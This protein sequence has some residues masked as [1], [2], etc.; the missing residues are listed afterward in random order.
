MI[1]KI[2]KDTLLVANLLASK[3][4]AMC[5]MLCYR[6]QIEGSILQ[7]SNRSLLVVAMDI[8]DLLYYYVTCI[9]EL[10]L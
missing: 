6:T 2:D 3:L 8:N 7:C 5:L 1:A 10:V 9:V 4:H